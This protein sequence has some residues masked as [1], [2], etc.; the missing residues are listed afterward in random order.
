VSSSKLVIIGLDAADY[1]LTRSLMDDGELPRLNAIRNAKNFSRLGS[2]VPPHTAPGWTSITTGVNPGKHGIYYFYDFSTIPPSIVNASKSSTPRIWDYVQASKEQSIVVN[3][4]VTYPVRE[5]FSGSIVSGIPPWFVDEKSV[6][7]KALLKKLEES[8]YEI[9]T[10]MSRTLEKDPEELVNRLIATEAKRVDIFLN[11][12][13]ESTWSFGM[14]VITALDRLQHKLVGKN[15]KED[16]EVR[17]GYREVDKLVGKIIDSLGKDVN[18]LVVSDHGFNHRPVAFYPNAWLYKNGFLKRKSSFRQRLIT[19]LHNF[20]DGRFLWLPQSLTKEFQGANTEVKSVDSVDVIDSRAFVPGTDGVVV[21]RSKDDLDSVAK[22]LSS[23]KDGNGEKVCEIFARS[24]IFSGERLESAPQLLMVPRSDV[25]VRSDPFSKEFVSTSGNF[26]R[27]NHS[28]EGILFAT[29]PNI[30]TC[31]GTDASLEDI[32]PTSLALLGIKSPKFMDGRV[33]REIMGE[34][35]LIDAK[36]SPIVGGMEKPF[37]FSEAEERLVM[38]SL[39]R[40][41][42]T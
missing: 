14:I 6:N 41:G 1:N 37:K 34:T 9:D 18:F 2:V 32:A 16:E 40:L 42:Y 7:S 26:P 15:V 13:N 19:D 8:G 28:P 33:L 20:F 35:P 38:E 12:L 31:E 11:L 36:S 10:P 24:Q 25:T 3:V 21:V 39:R 17:R 27:G 29:G 23:I 22:G 5:N 30:R 4:P